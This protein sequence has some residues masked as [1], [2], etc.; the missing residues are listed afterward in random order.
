MFFTILLIRMQLFARFTRLAREQ[1]HTSEGIMLALIFTNT[2]LGAYLSYII[3]EERKKS[4]Q[5]RVFWVVTI[6]L[7]ISLGITAYTLGVKES[8]IVTRTMFP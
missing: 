2:I 6:L 3:A 8:D 7:L 4:V 5:N 1:S